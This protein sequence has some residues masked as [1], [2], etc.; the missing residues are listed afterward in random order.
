MKKIYSIVICF[1][2]VLSCASPKVETAIIPAPA[3]LKA[4]SGVFN[5]KGQ[6]ISYSPELGEISAERIKEFAERLSLAC[7]QK[8]ELSDKVCECGIAFIADK[9]LAEEEYLIKIS[10]KGMQV[11]AA[12]LNGVVYALA[13]IRQMLPVAIYGREREPDAKWQLP[14]CEI[15]D[16]PRFTYRGMHLDISR[17][18]FDI[19]EVK[20][21]LDIMAE[22]KLNRFHWHLTDDQGWRIEIKKYPRLTEKGSR[23][24]GTMIGHLDSDDMKIVSDKKSYGG[25]Y[26]QDEI[27]EVVKYA[28]GLGITVVPEIDLPGHMLAALSAYPELGC[29]GGPYEVWQ[30]W[31]V[32]KDVLCAG[33]EKT[34]EF[35]ENVL[36]EIVELF[37]GEYIHIGGDECPKDAWR[38]CA[39]C[40]KRIKSLGIKGDEK[41]SAED[42]L[43]NYV[44]TRIQ[45]F[46]AAKGR[47]I[48]GWDE[49]LEG[50]LSEGATIM[51]WRGVAGGIEGAKKG[52]DVIMTP[53]SHLYFDF[54]Q[55]EEKEKEPLAI[56]GYTPLEKVYSFDPYEGLPEEARGHILGVQ[57]NLW[58]EYIVSDKQLEYM[59]LPRLQ[60]LSEVQWCKT[61]NM[62]YEVFKEK[63]TGRHFPALDKMG[64]NYSKAVEGIYGYW[65]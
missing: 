10:R 52:F 28:E 27:R 15:R 35:L 44:T 53:Y 2:A 11:R 31:G 4:G 56:G 26:T 6:K 20:K 46:L 61:E 50:R 34:F 43:Q 54:Y 22:Y 55:S 59:L 47:R 17:H 42:Y 37:P 14:C 57:A 65:K 16:Y 36:A 18:F 62:D 45:N 5:L 48:I 29:T 19:N 64:Y 23:R 9:N 12:S 7:G 49:I 51:S 40:R 25:F 33:K 21:Y 38:A 41:H 8:S 3:E 13:S 63:L 1:I 58:T 60:A 32:A 24:A 30:R 39:K